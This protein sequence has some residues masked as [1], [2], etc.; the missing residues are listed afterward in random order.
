MGGLQEVLGTVS[1][2]AE[3]QVETCNFSTQEGFIKNK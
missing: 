1:S 2:T 3:N